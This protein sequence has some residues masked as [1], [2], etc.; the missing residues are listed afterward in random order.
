[1]ALRARRRRRRHLLIY[2]GLTP[3]VIAAVFPVFW[4]AITAFK[5]DVRRSSSLKPKG[6]SYLDIGTSGV[7]L[8]AREPRHVAELA[9]ALA[10]GQ[11]EYI[12]LCKGVVRDKGSIRRPLVEQGLPHEARTRYT[13]REIVG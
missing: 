10:H 7:C 6:I 3:F 8:F 11:K 2:A 4:M 1:V 5:D 9:H 13:R 12:A